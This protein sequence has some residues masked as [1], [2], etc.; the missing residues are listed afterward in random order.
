[1]KGC[2]FCL[3]K[4]EPDYKKVDE[5]RRFMTERGKIVAAER[6]GLCRRHQKRLTIAVKRARIL[7]LVPFLVKAK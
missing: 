3:G 5:V 4:V 1:M 2:F 6:S 7:S